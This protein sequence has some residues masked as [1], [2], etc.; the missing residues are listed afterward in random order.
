MCTD[1]E[2]ASLSYSSM[3][4]WL[5]FLKGSFIQIAR[6]IQRKQEGIKINVSKAFRCQLS[7]GCRVNGC[8]VALMLQR[9]PVLAAELD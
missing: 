3:G 7:H 6:C 1:V 5:R 2:M 4:L 8:L 9:L